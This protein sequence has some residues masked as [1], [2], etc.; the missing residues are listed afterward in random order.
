MSAT[1]IKALKDRHKGAKVYVVGSGSSL[2]HLPRPLFADEVVIVVNEMFRHIAATY[3]LMHHTETAQ[4][5]LD[6]GSRLVISDRAY[7][8][9]HWG[10]PTELAGDYYVYRTTGY[11]LSLTPTIDAEHVKNR[12]D[13][14]LVVSACTMAEAI[15]FAAHLGSSA[16]VLCG[17]DGGT[18][19]GHTCLRGYNNGASTNPQHLRLTEPILLTVVHAIRAQ[20]IPV[21]SLNPFINFGLEGH[22]Y[23]QPSVP[24]D[25]AA[26]IAALQTENRELGWNTIECGDH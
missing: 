17:L 11:E 10:E 3:V 23:E 21:V 15:Q 14:E 5:A 7:D 18:L 20:G 6:A 12:Q 13:D 24:R 22:V 9:P 1:N 8:F 25:Q 2:D 26:L 19:D 4:E 16:I